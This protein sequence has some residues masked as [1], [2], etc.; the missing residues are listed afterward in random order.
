[1][2]GRILQRKQDLEDRMTAEVA[3]RIQV[4]YQLFKRRKS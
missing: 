4:F 1:M 3:L 2:G